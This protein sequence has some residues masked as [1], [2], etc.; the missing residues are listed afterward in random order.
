MYSSW[1]LKESEAR[2]TI[3][4]TSTPSRLLPAVFRLSLCPDKSQ[5]VLSGVH[6][7]GI[8]YPRRVSVARDEWRPCPDLGGPMQRLRLQQATATSSLAMPGEDVCHLKAHH[9]ELPEKISDVLAACAT[10][11]PM[12]CRTIRDVGQIG[13]PV[14]F[15]LHDGQ[16]DAA[17]AR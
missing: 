2:K 7:A 14:H 5:V 1:G 16:S 13:K 9:P 8:G 4:N 6:E 15:H 12:V 3:E 10:A 17:A 11:L